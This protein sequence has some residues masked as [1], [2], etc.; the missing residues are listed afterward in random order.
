[1]KVILSRKGFDAEAGGFPSP[2]LP[3]GELI[4]LPIPDDS[5]EIPYSILN[6]DN[7]KTSYYSFM[8]SLNK[9][10]IKVNKK[11]QTLDENT[12]CHLDPDITQHII[13]RADGW[14]GVFGQVDQSAGHLKNQ[15]VQPGDIFL[16]FGWFRK[17][18]ISQGEIVFDNDDKNGKHILFGYLQVG[19]IIH[20]NVTAPPY[21]WLNQHP[22]LADGYIGKASNTLYIARESLSFAKDLAGY[23]GFRYSPELELSK[24]EETKSKWALPDIFKDTDISYH[25]KKSWKDGHF[26]STHRGQEFVLTASNEI[27]CWVQ[28]IIERNATKKIQ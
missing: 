18:I 17:A 1:M 3:G 15:G 5:T 10:R 23:G 26:Q 8:R 22:H 28:G 19:E 20:P 9:G 16:F 21:A 24:D 7:N 25:T 14:R 6:C 27:K 13:G 4:S 2:I 11:W 12:T